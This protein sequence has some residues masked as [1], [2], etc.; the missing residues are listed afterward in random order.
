MNKRVLRQVVE[1]DSF[2]GAADRLNLSTASVSKCDARRTAP[3]DWLG[4]QKWADLLGEYRR[5]GTAKVPS[6]ISAHDFVTIGTVDS[7]TLEAYCSSSERFSQEPSTRPIY[8]LDF[9]ISEFSGKRLRVWAFGFSSSR[10]AQE[11]LCPQRR[12]P[13]LKIQRTVDGD[14]VFW[15]SGRLEADNLHELSTLL[16]LER[17]GWAI[18]LDLQDLVLVDVDA[19]GFLRECETKGITLR[20]CPPYIRIW[21]GSQG[22][23]A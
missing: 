17:S 13:V 10:V 7:V 22:D 1:M 6:D 19:V 14:V 3:R 4:A 21:I 5:R 11:L 16:E 20:N 23:Q 2:A 9:V 18:T 15:V 8:S 12:G